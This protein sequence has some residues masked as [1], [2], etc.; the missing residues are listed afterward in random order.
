MAAIE[1]HDP[2]TQTEARV[3][4]NG[5]RIPVADVDV[6]IRKEGNLDLTRYAEFRFPANWDGTN[7]IDAFDT[8][9]PHEQEGFDTVRIDLRDEGAY[10]NDRSE[11][12]TYYPAFIGVVTGVGNAES[13]PERF[14]KC[15]AQGPGHFLS[16]IP[17]STR[18]SG[19]KASILTDYIVEEID[20]RL[21]ITVESAVDTSVTAETNTDWRVGI[22]PILTALALISDT[23]NDALSTEKSF[24]ANKHTLADVADWVTDKT[25]SRLWFEPSPEGAVLVL[26]GN[27][28]ADS[29]HHRAHYLVGGGEPTDS[30][31]PSQSSVTED[32]S[33][34]YIVSNNAFAEIRPVNTIQVNGQAKRS[35]K[36]VGRYGQTTAQ[37]EFTAVKARHK[38]LYERAG[39]VELEGDTV[40]ETDAQSKSEVEN[41]AR[42]RLKEIVDESTAG[43]METLLRSPISPYDTVE[44]LPTCNEEA[45]ASMDPLTYEVQRVQHKIRPGEELPHTELMVGIETDMDEDVEIID[46]WDGE[47]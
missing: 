19:G 12:E 4:V 47:I 25:S 16:K 37:K 35:L 3:F 44:A 23:V 42:S 38:P 7:W 32:D 2:D 20:D 28:T 24:Q 40:T 15:R 27:P 5:S 31:L 45:A 29:N 43:S 14:W 9:S 6:H 30:T 18:F 10:R 39:G 13:G 8:H 41:E 11:S 36:S 34:T 46:K 21:P 33:L 17:A 1:D 26:S 22:S